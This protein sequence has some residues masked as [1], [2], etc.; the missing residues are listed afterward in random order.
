MA[1]DQKGLL[2]TFSPC[3]EGSWATCLVGV[4]VKVKVKAERR[5]KREGAGQELL[6]Q[7]MEHPNNR[8]EAMGHHQHYLELKELELVLL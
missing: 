6:L 3:S 7:V 5:V 1:R 8:L 2:G 4:K